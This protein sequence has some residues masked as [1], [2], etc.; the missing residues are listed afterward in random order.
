MINIKQVRL[1]SGQCSEPKLALGDPNRWL[2]M[3]DSAGEFT[4]LCLKIYHILKFFKV[5]NLI[6][7]FSVAL[8][9]TL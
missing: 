1:T 4:Y 3:I 5:T 7:K 2:K 9:Q 6:H 8:D